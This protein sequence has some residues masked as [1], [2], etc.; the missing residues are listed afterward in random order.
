MTRLVAGGLRFSPRFVS[1]H[2]ATSRVLWPC[3]QSAI[4][5]GEDGRRYYNRREMRGDPEPVC[6]LVDADTG[7]DAI[8]LLA[9]DAYAA[10]VAAGIVPSG[11]WYSANNL[12]ATGTGA[13]FTLP[14]TPYLISFWSQAS[15][16]SSKHGFAYWKINAAG[17]LE[18]VGGGATSGDG[19]DVQFD[20]NKPVAAGLVTDAAPYGSGEIYYTQPIAAA[21]DT[22]GGFATRPSAMIVLPSINYVAANTPIVDSAGT[23]WLSRGVDVGAMFVDDNILRLNDNPGSERLSRAFF[24]PGRF[25]QLFYKYD[26]ERHIAGTASVTSAWLAARATANPGGLMS[27]FS[28]SWTADVNDLWGGHPA[29]SGVTDG[30]GRVFLNPDGTE[31]YP[32]ADDTLNPDDTVGTSSKT[33]YCQ[34]TVYPSDPNDK[35]SP[36]LVFF[37]K[38][39]GDTGFET[40]AGVKVFAYYQSGY[41]ELIAEASGQLFASFPSGAADHRAAAINVAWDRDSGKLT[42]LMSCYALGEASFTVADFGWYN[43][44]IDES[45][46]NGASTGEALKLRAWPFELDGH[47]FYVLRCGEQGTRVYD[48]TT[49]AWSTFVTEGYTTWNAEHGVYWNGYTVVADQTQPKLWKLDPAATQDQGS[50][51]ITRIV[52]GGYP[53]RGRDVVPCNAVRVTA[54][55]GAPTAAA[56]TISLRWSDDAGQTWSASRSITLVNADYDQELAWRALGVMRAPG[57]VFEITDVGGVIRIDGADI[58]DG[59]SR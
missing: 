35:A 30:F 50:L 49:G 46:V 42:L 28:L 12:R 6:V 36:W 13:F 53:V 4:I 52:T 55:V 48:M 26:I 37:P 20:P 17:A 2:Y 56:P 9:A 58:E 7:L 3:P 10:V 41:A 47:A 33:Y 16:V 11:G 18:L 23:P 31:A 8:T 1:Q 14:G 5:K 43:P 40:Y 21:Y 27:A 45:G 15:G 38:V 51:D 59:R 57:R 34:P 32:F 39:F 19:I 22:S 29:A 44:V 25:C 54:S 24:L